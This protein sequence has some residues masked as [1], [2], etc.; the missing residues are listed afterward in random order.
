MYILK[1]EE[2]LSVLYG[3]HVGE[4][5][6]ATLEF[7]KPS[8]KENW[9]T[10]ILGEGILKWSA[11]QATDDI[12]MM[13]CLMRT[14]VEDPFNFNQKK[15]IN[16]FRNW[17]SLENP[18]DI[19]N[20]VNYALD[21]WER[22][23]PPPTKEDQQGNGSLMRVAPMILYKGNNLSKAVKDQAITT[24]NSSVV[25]EMDKIYIELLKLVIREKD[26]HII[27]DFLKKRGFDETKLNIKW[28]HLKTTGWTVD[29]FNAAVWSLFN[30]KSY[31]EGILKIINRGDDSDSVGC[32]AGGLLGAYYGLKNIPERWLNLIQ[33]KKEME[34]LTDTYLRK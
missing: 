22:G 16:R 34:E 11:G 4:A 20:T 18:R 33:F 23:N 9:Q 32:I 24:H 15:L 7:Q 3:A 26:K 6:G 29:S 12:D 8:T 31:E 27:L 2:I 30:S 28:K 1:K 13:M 19:G 5:L 17:R 14:I 25:V 10:E 21:C